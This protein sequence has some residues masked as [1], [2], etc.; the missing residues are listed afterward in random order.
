MKTSIA[1]FALPKRI[2]VTV[3]RPQ[4]NLS[5]AID[6]LAQI[7]RELK[8]AQSDGLDISTAARVLKDKSIASN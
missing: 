3:Q 2:T 6:A 8:R 4:M 5:G 7:L 1:R